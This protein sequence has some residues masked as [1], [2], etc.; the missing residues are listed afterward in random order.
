MRPSLS[1]CSVL[2][3]CLRLR[4][5]QW[6]NFKQRIKAPMIYLR[7][8]IFPYNCDYV[9]SSTTQSVYHGRERGWL[10]FGWDYFG[11]IWTL[12]DLFRQT[13]FFASKTEK[14]F[15]A[16]VIW[17]KKLSFVW[18]DPKESKWAQN[19]P[20]WSKICYIDHFGSFWTLVDH[21]GTS[22]TLPCLVIFDPKR[23]FLDPPAHMIK[24]WQGPKLLQ[25][26][27]IYV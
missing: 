4:P 15:L 23:A 9:L 11:P 5:M 3:A 22:A 16:K 21:F 19:G 17:S 18:K 8:L 6:L 13:W 1:V 25:T 2:N 27:F 10:L 7:Y 24:G 26:N 14:C 20:K 12:L